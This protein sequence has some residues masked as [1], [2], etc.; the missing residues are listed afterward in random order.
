MNTIPPRD[1]RGRYLAVGQRVRARDADDAEGW[2]IV[3]M[4]RDGRLV[5]NKRMGGRI[6]QS[7]WAQGLVERVSETPA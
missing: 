3:G 4:R 7:L 2:L 5:L 1:C 6:H